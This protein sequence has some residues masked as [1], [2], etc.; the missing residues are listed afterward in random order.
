M[1]SMDKRTET[2]SLR[3]PEITKTK[4]DRLSPVWKSE[5]NDKL[6]LTIA[7]VLHDSEFDPKIYLS[8]E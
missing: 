7:K 2:Y 6:L 4:I 5:L 1:G 3:V 8:S